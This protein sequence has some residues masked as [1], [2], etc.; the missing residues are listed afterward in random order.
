MFGTPL[1]KSNKVFNWILLQC[2]KY[3]Y[4]TRTAKKALNIVPFLRILEQEFQVQKYLLL[5]N[6]KFSDYNENWRS[7][8]DIF[9]KHP[10]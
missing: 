7:W 1:N 8:I 10:T 4:S 9:G 5:K 3:I 2:K 6:C